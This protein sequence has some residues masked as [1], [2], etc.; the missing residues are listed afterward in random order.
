MRTN[1]NSDPKK[2]GQN[3]IN[4]KK[5]LMATE[6]IWHHPKERRCLVQAVAD[7]HK[8][9]GQFHRVFSLSRPKYLAVWKRVTPFFLKTG[10]LTAGG[11]WK[12]AQ[13]LTKQK[14]PNVKKSENTRSSSRSEFCQGKICLKIH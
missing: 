7:E 1:D 4:L 5:I 12:K 2:R 10:T 11:K 3:E 8:T 9:F 6:F 14:I 13:Q